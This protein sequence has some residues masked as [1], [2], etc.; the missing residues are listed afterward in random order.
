M[1]L[2]CMH[3]GEKPRNMIPNAST[4]TDPAINDRSERRKQKKTC[5]F[6]IYLGMSCNIFFGN[7][8]NIDKWK[9]K[10]IQNEED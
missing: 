2:V 5:Q 4:E 10:M 7:N 8:Y 9:L 6:W 1:L 3:A